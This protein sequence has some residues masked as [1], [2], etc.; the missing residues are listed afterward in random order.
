MEFA[1]AFFAEAAPL[2]PNRVQAVG[3]GVAR[4]YGFG[5]GQHIF[6]HHGAAPNI[7]MRTDAHVLM[8]RTER[9]HAG[10]IFYGYVSG[11]RGSVCHDHVVA[12]HAI[13]RDV[14]IGHDQAM[15]ANAGDSAAAWRSSMDGDELS[16]DV[17]VSDFKPRPFALELQI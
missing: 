11:E 16:D 9:A 2:Q 1:D 17:V 7:G 12:N 13:V 10:P 8:H 5:E 4:G 15:I 6:G 14:G 3:S